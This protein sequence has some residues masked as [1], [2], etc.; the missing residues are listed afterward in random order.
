MTSRRARTN[1]PHNQLGNSNPAN[2]TSAQL[3]DALKELGINISIL[4]SRGN[5][6]KL[7]LENVKNGVNESV[8]RKLIFLTLLLIVRA[9]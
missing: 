2:W 8:G 7:Y 6:K 1:L 5:L 9:M 3:K 4:L